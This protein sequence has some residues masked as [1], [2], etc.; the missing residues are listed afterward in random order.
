MAIL[1]P[2]CEYLEKE[3]TVEIN[4]L[5][6]SIKRTETYRTEKLKNLRR[7]QELLVRRIRNLKK[8]KRAYLRQVA[9]L[10]SEDHVETS[11]PVDYYNMFDLPTSELA[12][13]RDVNI[14]DMLRNPADSIFNYIRENFRSYLHEIDRSIRDFDYRLSKLSLREQK[15]REDILAITQRET[16][17]K[18]VNDA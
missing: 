12:S 5:A 10:S 4:D 6:D 11:M 16:A 7:D 15:I 9:I 8:Q 18:E 1:R 13:N 14:K 2:R 17:P 3:N